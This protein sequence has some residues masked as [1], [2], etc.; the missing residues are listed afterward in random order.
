MPATT[1]KHA[2]FRWSRCDLCEAP[3]VISIIVGEQRWPDVE[4]THLEDGP[5]RLHAATPELRV[6]IDATCP[7]CDYPEMGFAQKRDEFACSHCGHAQDT[8]PGEDEPDGAPC[9]P[10]PQCSGNP[11]TFPGYA[12]NH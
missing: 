8:R 12:D 9:C 10:D 3:I 5:I 6:A 4:W 2:E 1:D 7:N 11:C